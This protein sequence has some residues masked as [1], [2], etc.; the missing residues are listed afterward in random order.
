MPPSPRARLVWRAL[1]YTVIGGLSG[2]TVGLLT[3]LPQELM[4]QEMGYAASASQTAWQIGLGVCSA[5]GRLGAVV[6]FIAFLLRRAVSGEMADPL[7]STTQ[8]QALR[9]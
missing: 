4:A 2:A 8:A 7:A 9:D 5:C 3:Y 6:G 1:K